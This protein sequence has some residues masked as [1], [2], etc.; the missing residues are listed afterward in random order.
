MTDQSRIGLRHG[1][2]RLPLHFIGFDGVLGDI[3][4]TNTNVCYVLDANVILPL[5]RYS[6]GKE[7]LPVSYRSF[8]SVSKKVAQ[9]AWDA[10]TPKMAIDPIL[11]LIE[12]TKQNEHPDIGKFLK[13]YD[14]FL[15]GTYGIKEYHPAW[16]IQTYVAAMAAQVGTLPSIVVTLEKTYSL[17][18]GPDRLDDDEILARCEELLSWLW[19]NHQKLTLIGGPLLYAAV[20]AIA[21]SPD[22]RNLVKANK[23]RKENQRVLAKNVAWDLLYWM[24]M[25]V[26]YHRAALSDCV[27]CTSDRALASLLASRVNRGPRVGLTSDSPP[28]TIESY[29]TITPF[30]FRRLENTQLEKRIVAM[31]TKFQ[32]FLNKAEAESFKFGFDAS[33]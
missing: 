7:A 21:G 5:L 28:Q 31:L 10:P 14:E 15:Q 8:L 19:Q 23:A 2:E 3:S 27:I 32:A 12:L 4:P 18:E 1:Q 11:G 24:R 29:G 30:K 6:S 33:L 26:E 13:T 25:E 9:Q 16:V 20:F 17:T 22:A